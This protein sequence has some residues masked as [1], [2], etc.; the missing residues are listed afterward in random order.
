M[1]VV[2]LNHTCVGMAEV[3]LLHHL[4]R[5]QNFLFQR[6]NSHVIFDAIARRGRTDLVND[7]TWR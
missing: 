5:K 6:N 7:V 2:L 1:T 3:F 4:A